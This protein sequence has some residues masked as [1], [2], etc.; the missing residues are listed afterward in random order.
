MIG[1][2]VKKEPETSKVND[3][4][5]HDVVC[6]DEDTHDV[7]MSSWDTKGTHV[8]GVSSWDTKGILLAHQ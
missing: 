2:P 8:V 5:K 6:L 1:I 3:G 7:G 4:E